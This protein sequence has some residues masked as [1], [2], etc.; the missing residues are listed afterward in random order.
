M[1]LE[2][3]KLPASILGAIFLTVYQIPQIVRIIKRKSS[4]D[5]SLPAYVF[6]WLGLLCYVISTIGTPANIAAFVSFLNVNLIICVIL[7]YRSRSKD[8]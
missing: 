6:V 4:D 5:F 8:V 7:N 3:A 2:T 1:I